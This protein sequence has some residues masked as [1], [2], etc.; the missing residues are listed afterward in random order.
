MKDLVIGVV[1]ILIAL[2]YVSMGSWSHSYIERHDRIACELTTNDRSEA[3]RDYDLNEV[4]YVMGAAIWPVIAPL[5]YAL[6]NPL[7][8]GLL[9]PLL[10]LSTVGGVVGG[11]AGVKRF[12]GRRERKQNHYHAELLLA[13]RRLRD[14]DP[15]F[16]ASLKTE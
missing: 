7:H 8:F 10:T 3:C 2:W 14:L 13:E 6:R 16:A 4:F 12:R 15:T 1:F 5:T 9:F 11:I